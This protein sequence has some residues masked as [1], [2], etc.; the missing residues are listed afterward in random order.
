MG[1]TFS[2]ISVGGCF[3]LGITTTGVVYAWGIGTGG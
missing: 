1:I 2:Q 3:S